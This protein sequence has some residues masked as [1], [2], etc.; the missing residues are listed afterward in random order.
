MSEL[1]AWT[2]RSRGRFRVTKAGE[3]EGFREIVRNAGFA[4][5][6]GGWRVNERAGATAEKLRALERACLEPKETK[7]IE[8]DH[9]DIAVLANG[10]FVA[11]GDGA[12]TVGSDTWLVR[13][14]RTEYWRKLW[15]GL[16]SIGEILTSTGA[17]D[18]KPASAGGSAGE[19]ALSPAESA[20]VSAGKLLRRTGQ[21]SN[22]S[23]ALN[24]AS[25]GTRVH[26]SAQ[27]TLACV[28]WHLIAAPESIAAPGP[29]PDTW[30][31]CYS[32]A[33]EPFRAG[34][35][36]GSQRRPTPTPRRGKPTAL[37][38][39]PEPTGHPTIHQAHHEALV[40]VLGDD[41]IVLEPQTAGKLDELMSLLEGYSP[42]VLCYTGHAEQ[43][44]QSVL[45]RGSQHYLKARELK[46]RLE[47]LARPLSVVYLNACNTTVPARRTE[48]DENEDPLLT[49]ATTWL[50]AA[51]CVVASR[52]PLALETAAGVNHDRTAFA[53]DFFRHLAIGETAGSA[54]MHARVNDRNAGRS[55][56]TCMELWGDSATRLFERD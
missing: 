47:R 30:G 12:G 22:L 13:D 2:A 48:P 41:F 3:Q 20:V 31:T 17:H 7:P 14:D 19:F 27:G 54:I 36:G 4:P 15:D 11:W 50:T 6:G 10:S 56:W 42:Q 24:S 53:A 49:L 55:T 5:S 16:E 44:A 23:Q 8:L 32:L 9:V 1:W 39:Y 43:G 46:E 51:R 38:L 33:V 34:R 35:L 29:Y 52:A 28:P 26:I 40:R 37:C 25:R 18:G 21:L 45:L